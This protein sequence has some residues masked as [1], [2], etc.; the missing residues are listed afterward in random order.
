[1]VAQI[2]RIQFAP[3]E[4]F[5]YARTFQQRVKDAWVWDDKSLEINTKVY[6]ELTPEGALRKVD[7]R[8]TSGNS[9]FDESVL[10]AV[11]KAAP[12]PAPPSSVYQY[13][14]SMVLT[15]DPRE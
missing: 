1:M 7:L 5:V 4:F 9:A 13:F 8:R 10:A 14:K 2:R 11:K 15:F 12:F 6:I 3:H